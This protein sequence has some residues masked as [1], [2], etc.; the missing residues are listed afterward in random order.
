MNV[1]DLAGLRSAIDTLKQSKRP[2]LV[3]EAT[4]ED[5][6]KKLFVD[7]KPGDGTLSELKRP[8]HTLVLGRKGTGKS[9]LFQRLQIE[10]RDRG[11]GISAY[12]DLKGLF[13]AAQTASIQQAF[14]GGQNAANA[15]Y[16]LELCLWRS[17]IAATVGSLIE[18][19]PTNATRNQGYFAKIFQSHARAGEGFAKLADIGKYLEGTEIDRLRRCVF[20]DGSAGDE[21]TTAVS[22]AGVVVSGSPGIAG[23]LGRSMSQASRFHTLRNRQSVVLQQFRVDQF[24]KDLR[25]A[26]QAEGM[27]YLY[28]IFDDFSELSDDAMKLFAAC[29]LEP[30][31]NLAHDIVKFKIAAY[32]GRVILGNVDSGR[33]EVVALDPHKLFTAREAPERDRKGIEF[34]KRLVTNRVQHFCGYDATAFFSDPD[35]AEKVWE[36]LYFASAAN[37]RG[38]GHI[39]YWILE[40]ELKDGKKITISSVMKAAEAHFT[41]CLDRAF[42]GRFADQPLEARGTVLTQKDLLERLVSRAQE[43]NEKARRTSGE[44]QNIASIRRAG[45][46]KIPVSHFRISPRLEDFLAPL[47]LNSFVTKYADVHDAIGTTYSVYTFNFGLCQI[48]K[49]PWYG[50]RLAELNKR[51]YMVDELDFSTAVVGYYN[52]SVEYACSSCPHIAP[53]SD[54]EHLKRY[55]MLCPS[56]HQ[57]EMH[58]RPVRLQCGPAPVIPKPELVLSEEEFELV[59]VLGEAK[60]AM[61]SQQMSP[62]LDIS[63]QQVGLRATALV[64]RGIVER[65]GKVS[66]R[67]TYA[68]SERAKVAYHQ[69]K[70]RKSGALNLAPAG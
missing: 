57:G 46:G 42:S 66:G 37:P 29:I 56:C 51:F 47:E 21:S 41:D 34:V 22:G 61:S 12:I 63:P 13:Q 40:N 27:R 55:A 8:S 35:N 65:R 64:A 58:E 10:I 9:T 25:A 32:P 60:R 1:V 52:E 39:L 3:D 54:Y 6:T 2:Q 43:L 68:L 44:P 19:L 33:F 50:P 69:I 26:L 11:E 15:N 28:L 16:A 18:E 38:L 24:I 48:Y 59:T 53:G 49:L 30:F 17:F 62:E 5:L 67:M 31:D 7:P 45:D 14:A 23:G 4:S 36:T 70:K 20:E